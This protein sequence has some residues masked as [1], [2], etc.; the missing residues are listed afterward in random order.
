MDGTDKIAL[1][2]R[3]ADG[4]HRPGA[5]FALRPVRRIDAAA[6]IA[7]VDGPSG[8]WPES[9]ASKGQSRNG[10]TS[11]PNCNVHHRL[12]HGVNGDVAAGLRVAKPIARFSTIRT[13]CRR[14][15][16]NIFDVPRFEGQS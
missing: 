9:P 11:I 1:S 3:S 2:Q 5:F 6:T 8:Q 13:D 7:N 4:N 14:Y 16:A 15:N 10:Q 12:W